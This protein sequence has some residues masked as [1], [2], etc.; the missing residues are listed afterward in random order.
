[1]TALLSILCLLTLAAGLRL[2]ESQQWPPQQ[3]DSQYWQSVLD[4]SHAYL[5]THSNVNAQIRREVE[6]TIQLA[7]RKLA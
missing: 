5:A 3:F 4:N 6:R 2:L 1:M 7:N